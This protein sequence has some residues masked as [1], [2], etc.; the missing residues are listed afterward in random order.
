M[1]VY[2]KSA[3]KNWWSAVLLSFVES[4]GLTGVSGFLW[5]H[6]DANVHSS[7]D[8]AGAVFSSS[9]LSARD[10]GYQEHLCHFVLDV[11]E[12]MLIVPVP[13]VYQGGYSLKGERKF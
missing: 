9:S 3:K 6:R 4:T 8:A 10:K 7:Y 12:E 5:R 1:S 11:H 2:L 13:S